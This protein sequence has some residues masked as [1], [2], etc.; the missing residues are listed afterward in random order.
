MPRL[1]LRGYVTRLIIM[2]PCWVAFS[3]GAEAQI[4]LDD[5]VYTRFHLPIDSI[6]DFVKINCPRRGRP[7]DIPYTVQHGD[8]LNATKIVIR[9]PH[10]TIVYFFMINKLV[11]VEI[12]YSFSPNETDRF[13]TAF[14][15]TEL[16]LESYVKSVQQFGKLN[17]DTVNKLIGEDCVISATAHGR[18]DLRPASKKTWIL[19]STYYH[20]AKVLQLSARLSKQVVTQNGYPSTECRYHIVATVQSR[21]S[22]DIMKR[23][24]EYKSIVYSNNEEQ[25]AANSS[26]EASPDGNEIKLKHS[27]SVYYIPVLVNNTLTLD[28]VFDSGAADV[29]LTPDVVLTMLRAG[30]LKESD[31][32]GSQQYQFADGSVAKSRVFM[33][34]SLKIG[35]KEISN[36]KAS[37]ATS[38]DAPLLLGQSAISKLGHLTFDFDKG[39]L[40]F[41]D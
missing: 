28:F 8:R 16:Y 17:A 2:V 12:D 21:R 24:P 36:I 6:L 33:L 10:A 15:R 38:V 18:A 29:S 20:D 37:V 26:S 22:E 1:S 3:H 41:R 13:K 19:D 11:S 25:S 35:N 32:I 9:Q 34:K 27:N 7:D 40:R 14:D 23:Y 5:I 31:F 39:I 4:S 30:L